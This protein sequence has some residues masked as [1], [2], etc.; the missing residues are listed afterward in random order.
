[1]PAARMPA[2]VLRSLLLALHGCSVLALHADELQTMRTWTSADGATLRAQL[3]NIDPSAETLRIRRDDGRIF[4]LAWERLS[5]ADRALL[6]DHLRPQQPPAARTAQAP[7]HSAAE[8]PL[9]DKFK[10]R[11]V[12][13]IRQKGAFCVPASAAMIAGFHG[14]KTDQ[15][16]IAQLSSRASVSHQGTRP[17]DMLHAMQKLGFEGQSLIWRDAERFERDALPTI[18]RSLVTTG[19]I[20]ISFRPG[21]FGTMGHGC[22][23]VGYN[24]RKQKLIFHNPWGTVFE[25]EYTEVA[26][27]GHGI[28]L[29]KPPQPAPTA[30]SAFIETIKQHVPYFSGDMLHLCRQLKQR[31]LPVELAWC[32]RYDSRADQRFAEQTARRDGR[33]I[34]ELAF[35]RNAA[36]LIPASPKG[37]TEHYLFVT[38]PPQG[39]A[40]FMVHEID[41]NG[42]SAPQLKTLGS[43]TRQWATELRLPGHTERVW[44]LPMIE[45]SE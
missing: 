20:Y 3:L 31:G 29:V 8:T 41:E 33:K 23:I 32:S 1:M 16:E 30:S 5:D 7:L 17:S 9:P 43:L 18:R 45:L 19:P 44:E 13:M 27:Q 24:H 10:L 4:T 42:W 21:V 6:Q 40:A 12:P 22:V 11:K 37:Q 35:E 25:K 14:I 39:G 28:V 26:L 15:D 34:L 36:V 38:R 2:A